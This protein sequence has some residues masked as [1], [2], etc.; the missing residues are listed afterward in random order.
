M[1]HTVG[2]SPKIVKLPSFK[3]A[4]STGCRLF[5]E[6]ELLNLSVSNRGKAENYYS[7]DN[8]GLVLSLAA[9]PAMKA[10]S[11]SVELVGRVAAY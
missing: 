9:L 8:I 11:F 7:F 5:W 3:A 4:D 10:E 6:Y 2:Q 1:S